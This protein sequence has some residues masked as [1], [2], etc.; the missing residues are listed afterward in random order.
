MSK[1][2][3]I[4][5]YF[6][7]PLLLD[8][9]QL[10]AKSSITRPRKQ[11]NKQKKGK[12]EKQ[13]PKTN[14][15]KIKQVQSSVTRIIEEK[16]IETMEVESNVEKASAEPLSI[17]TSESSFEEKE[18]EDEPSP[19]RKRAASNAQLQKMCVEF[20]S[21]RIIIDGELLFCEACSKNVS[22]KKSTLKDHILC[23]THING[24]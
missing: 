8:A 16:S 5:S 18:Q 3:T 24:K 22:P 12:L 1:K 2:A 11:Q 9:A 15:L 6:T 23:D 4:G 20:K 10:A 13:S 21:E 19:K 17:S 7:K 14:I